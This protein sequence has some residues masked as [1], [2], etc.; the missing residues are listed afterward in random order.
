MLFRSYSFT[1]AEHDIVRDEEELADTALDFDTEMQ[2]ATES[3]DKE[4]TYEAARRHHHH[5]WQRALPLP[6]GALPAEVRGQGGQRY[7]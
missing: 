3:S 4:E 1:T 7:P 2:A 5:C 6:R